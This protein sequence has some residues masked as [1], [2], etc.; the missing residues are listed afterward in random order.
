MFRVLVQWLLG[1]WL[2]LGLLVRL[3]VWNRVLCYQVQWLS[4]PVFVDLAGLVTTENAAE[5][6]IT[7][8]SP[9]FT[10]SLSSLPP[11]CAMG[12]SPSVFFV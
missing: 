11:L 12:T 2:Q 4:P 7:S 3:L 8:P 10:Q 5:V 6:F 9:G 1:L